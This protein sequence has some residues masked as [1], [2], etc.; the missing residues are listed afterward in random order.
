MSYH[1]F[2]REEL[3]KKAKEKYDNGGKE[4]AAKYYRE[5][6]DVIKERKRINIENVRRRK[7]SKT[8]VLKNRY[9][10]L[11]EKLR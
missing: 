1:W 5:N 11:K 9:K 2:N 3:L 7:R 8:A 6:K 4:R 10:K